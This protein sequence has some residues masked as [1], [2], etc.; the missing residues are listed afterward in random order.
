MANC[1]NSFA[2]AKCFFIDMRMPRHYV[3]QAKDNATPGA[4]N[5]HALVSEILLWF[6][7]TVRG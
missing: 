3:A 5:I 4:V 6:G 2:F 7:I 1:R